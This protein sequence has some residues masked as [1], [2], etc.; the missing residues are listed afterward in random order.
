MQHRNAPEAL[1]R[2]LRDIRNDNR[3]FGSLTVVF[4]G[5]FQQTLPVVPK[6]SREEIVNATIQRSYL[7]NDVEILHLKR[8]MRLEQTQDEEEQ[9]FARWL[10]DVGHGRGTS[11][12][13]ALK[14]RDEL[15]CADSNA[16]PYTPISE[17]EDQHP[18][19]S[20]I[21]QYWPHATRTSM[22]STKRFWIAWGVKKWFSSVP[23]LLTGKQVLMVT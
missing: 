21:A 17:A 6:G 15:V 11:P 13:G 7:W 23:T 22:E 9:E 19:T 4:G 18:S 14:L 2:T 8:N 12:D 20:S 16:L 5:D 1:D 10:L 3:P